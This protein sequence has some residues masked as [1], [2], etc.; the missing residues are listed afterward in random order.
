[1]YWN[2]ISQLNF[3][4]DQFS[5]VV[6][7]LLYGCTTWTL[8]RFMKRKLD[9][10]CTKMLRAALNKSWKQHPTKEHLYGHLCPISKIIQI[11]QTRHAGRCWRSKDERI[12]VVLLWAL[13][14]LCASVGRST[15]TY[16]QQLFTDRGCSLEDL[17]EAVDDWDEW[18]V[19]VREI[20]A[21]SATWWIWLVNWNHITLRNKCLLLRVYF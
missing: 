2:T 8:A 16:L 20:R 17:S 10:N 19:R 18:C 4:K 12:R 5:A 9:S 6:S 3:R 1:M 14:H 7:V 15:S 21:S 13:I 11:R